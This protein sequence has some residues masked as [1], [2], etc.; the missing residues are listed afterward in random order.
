MTLAGTQ[1]GPSDPPGS[2]NTSKFDAVE[3]FDSRTTSVDGGKQTR[4][5]RF[6]VYANSGS[7]EVI[8]STNL[9]VSLT[10]VAYGDT[11]PENPLL[12]ALGL[13]VRVLPETGRAAMEVLWTY[14]RGELDDVEPD[15]PEA[16]EYQSVDLSGEAQFFDVFR[17]DAALP[18]GGN[19]PAGKPDIG[20]TPVDVAGEPISLLLV[21]GAFRVQRNVAL[22]NYSAVQLLDLTGTRNNAPYL[23]FP[24]GAVLYG[25][26]QASRIAQGVMRVTHQLLV[27]RDRLH[28]RQQAQADSEGVKLSISVPGGEGGSHAERVY[29]VQPFPLLADFSVLGITPT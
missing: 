26:P 1:G 23:G 18:S 14:R 17:Q 28:L 21:T 15:D 6:I 2:G 20:G 29:H 5:R 8:K 4:T 12:R 7:G 13:S 11:H 22:S 16:P 25:R 24:T 9:A 19:P 10:G 27:D 3:T